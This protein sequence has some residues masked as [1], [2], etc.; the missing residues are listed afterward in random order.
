MAHNYPRRSKGQVPFLTQDSLIDLNISCYDSSTEQNHANQNVSHHGVNEN[1][2]GRGGTE[3]TQDRQ[4]YAND[5]R[6]ISGATELE[7]LRAQKV[8]H[9]KLIK[10]HGRAIEEL[11]SQVAMLVHLIKHKQ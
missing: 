2:E 9:E 3:D 1:T 4:S 8:S 11:T 5:A 7:Q 6:R 10:K